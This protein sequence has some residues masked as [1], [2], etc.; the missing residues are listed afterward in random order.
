VQ[1]PSVGEIRRTGR[2]LALG[3]ILGLLMTLW[4]RRRVAP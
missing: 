2:A 3:A 4:S 1:A